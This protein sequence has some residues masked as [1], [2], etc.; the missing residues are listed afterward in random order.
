MMNIRKP[1]KI[2]K[3]DF[4]RSDILKKKGRHSDLDKWICILLCIIIML[5][6]NLFQLE[7]YS[8]YIDHCC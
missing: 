4:T 1:F 7:S 6:C 5:L 3:S 8:K 2:L